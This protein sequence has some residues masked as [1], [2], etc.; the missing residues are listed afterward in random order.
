LKH[1]VIELTYRVP[2]S[3]IEESSAAHRTYIQAGVDQG[4]ILCA[5]PRVPREGGIILAR[6]DSQATLEA[7]FAADPYLR[8][9]LAEYR[10]LEFLPLRHQAALAD[11][12]GPA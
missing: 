1:F 3:R 11:W 12:V 9:G 4:L 8:E 6:A 7:F 5:G 2:L 10:Y